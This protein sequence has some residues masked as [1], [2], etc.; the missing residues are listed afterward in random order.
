MILPSAAWYRQGH[1]T[2]P[3]MRGKMRCSFCEQGM[4][5]LTHR[6]QHHS[7]NVRTLHDTNVTLYSPNI[8]F[9]GSTPHLGTRDMQMW[10]TGA[11]R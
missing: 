7:R 4:P 8:A 9:P 11:V 5:L 3:L 10:E 1:V 6:Y 2:L